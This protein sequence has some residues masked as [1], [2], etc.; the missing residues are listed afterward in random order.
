VANGGAGTL[1]WSLGGG[2]SLPD[3]LSLSGTGMI[4]GTPT[5]AS[6]TFNFKVHV[7]DSGNPPLTSADVQ[8]TIAVAAPP[9]SVALSPT[10]AYVKLNGS[11]KFVATLTND[12]PNGKVDWTITLNGMSC[13]V[14]ECGSVSPITT[15]SAAPT[16]YTAPASVPPANITLTATT[17]DGTPPATT[18]AAVTVGTHSFVPTNGSMKTDRE[19]H[20]ATLLDHGWALTNGKVLVAGGNDSTGKALASA[21]LFDPA[22]GGTFAPTVSIHT[23]RSRHTATLLSDGK[24]LLTGGLDSNNQPLASAELFDPANGGTFTPTQGNMRSPRAYHTATLLANGTVLVS[25]GFDG[26]NGLATAELFDPANCGTFTPTQGD[27]DSP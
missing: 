2:T 18:S 12:Q 24:V 17:V 8:L 4:A 25:G 6:A 21:E 10:S 23:A 7:T 20:T 27:M 9:I 13:P 14:A 26:K 22:N 15:T 5:G 1:T 16:T 19:F 3:T 11:T